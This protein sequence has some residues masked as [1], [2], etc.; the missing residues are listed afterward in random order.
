M[1]NRKPQLATIVTTIGVAL[2]IL[3]AGLADHRLRRLEYCLRSVE[4]R[5]VRISEHLG[6]EPVEIHADLEPAEDLAA[7]W[8]IGPP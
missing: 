6:M 3:V 4:L 2:F 1:N 7:A 5:V 8:L